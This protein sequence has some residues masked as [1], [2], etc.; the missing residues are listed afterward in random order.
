MQQRRHEVYSLHLMG[1]P[2]RSRRSASNMKVRSLVSLAVTTTTRAFSILS[3]HGGP[4][5]SFYGPSLLRKYPASTRLHLNR[6][7]IDPVELDNDA[8]T[9]SNNTNDQQEDGIVTVTIPKDDYRTIH[10]AKI[11]GLHNGDT[12]RAGIVLDPSHEDDDDDGTNE[13]HCPHE[14]MVADTA[15]IQW[16]PEGKVKKAEPLGNGN[17]PGSLRITLHNLQPPA[18]TSTPPV[19]LIL[20]LPRPLQLNR[21][22]PMICQMGVDRLILTGAKKVPRDY[23]GSHLFR[24]PALLRERCME[25]LCQA[26]TDVRLPRITVVRNLHQFLR[27][28]LDELF[29]QSTHA[30]VMAHPERLVIKGTTATPGEPEIVPVTGRFEENVQF[31]T[32]PHETL[33]KTS[34]PRRVVLAVGPEGGW[35]EPQ[36]LDLLMREHHFQA[37]TLGP[38]VLRSDVAVVALMALAHEACRSQSTS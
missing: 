16:I 5:G 4:L 25:G 38:R 20:A 7:L 15:T 34:P 14:G 13:S 8:T 1:R 30:R 29:P 35:D 23:F 21:M 32:A 10:A 37:V 17:P 36:E 24:R 6:F 28:D 26:G 2:L 18:T 19:S 9:W 11:L 22:L 31:P 27:D 33:E 3:C 12:V